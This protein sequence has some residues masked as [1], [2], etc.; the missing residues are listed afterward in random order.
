VSA[1]PR[2]LP[3][4]AAFLVG[5]DDATGARVV[6]PI[7]GEHLVLVEPDGAWRIP[8]RFRRAVLAAADPVRAARLARERTKGGPR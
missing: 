2:P 7:G 5:V 1:E 3:P 8:Q 4:G 6:A